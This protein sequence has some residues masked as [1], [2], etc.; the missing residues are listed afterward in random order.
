MKKILIA[1]ILLAIPYLCLAQDLTRE[2]ITA[3]VLLKGKTL[4]ITDTLVINYNDTLKQWDGTQWNILGEGSTNFQGY[5]VIIRNDSILVDTS[6][7]TTLYNITSK[8]DKADT[9]LLSGYKTRYSS[10]LDSVKQ[11]NQILLKKDKSDSTALTG[12]NTNYKSSLKVDKTTTVNSKA[13]IGNITLTSSDFAA[14]DSATNSVQGFMTATDHTRLLNAPSGSGV[15]SQGAYWNGTNSVTGNEFWAVDAVNKK[16]TISQI[17]LIQTRATGLDLTNTTPATVSVKNQDSPSFVLGGNSW[18]T[19]ASQSWPMMVRLTATSTSTSS[20]L[21]TLRFETSQDGAYSANY[22][23]FAGGIFSGQSFVASQYGSFTSA[24]NG[25][26]SF[27][28]ALSSISAAL[29]GYN[30]FAASAAIKIQDAP[31][32]DFSSRLWNGSVSRAHKWCV[33]TIG[34]ADTENNNLTFWYSYDGGTN[35]KKIFEIQGTYGISA[36][37]KFFLTEGSG[38]T[39]PNLSMISTGKST[40]IGANASN[41]YIVGD[42]SA[43]MLLTFASKANIDAG[44]SLGSTA[45]QITSGG[46]IYKVNAVTDSLIPTSRVVDKKIAAAT[47]GA[48]TTVGNWD[49]SGNAFPTTGSGAGGIVDIGDKWTISVKG[50]VSG[51]SLQVG[52]VIIAKIA[53]PGQ[54]LA[55]WNHLSAASTTVTAIART[56]GDVGAGY[57][58]YNGT[59]SK[60]G[61][62]DGGTTTPTSLNKTLNFNG[63]FKSTNLNIFGISVLNPRVTDVVGSVG[64]LFNT[65]HSLTAANNFIFDFKNNNTSVLRYSGDGWLGINSYDFAK[66]I[67]SGGSS[68]GNRIWNIAGSLT[69]NTNNTTATGLDVSSW[70]GKSLNIAHRCYTSSNNTASVL[71]INRTTTSSG[72]STGNLVEI[73]DGGGGSGSL[74]GK[75]LKVVLGS[76]STSD[77]T[78]RIYF[79]PRVISTGSALAYMFDTHTSLGA[80][81][82]IVSFLNYGTEMSSIDATGTISYTGSLKSSVTQTTVNG[83]TSG[84]A[85]F[86]PTMQGASEKKVIIY[87][88]ALNG[89]A[90]YTFPV[91]FTYTPDKLGSNVSLVTSLSTTGITVTGSTSTGFIE[92]YGF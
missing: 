37:N 68:S 79:N 12:F 13:L 52:D 60:E 90:T 17:N 67:T 91:A 29:Y 28:P 40:S 48:L 14:S 35:V 43:N 24:R 20:G 23:T 6:K 57:L 46:N 59:V 51:D 42:N 73:I 78:E 88:N 25:A 38:G 15:S 18:G 76:P 65:E 74:S 71:N 21:S 72:N 63:I 16:H 81:D 19:T 50:I 11:Y 49:A 2:K 86:S 27:N 34:A 32:I 64:Y 83:S 33:R 69:L 36:A 92:I 75:V 56:A 10:D 89:T 47:N 53:S 31:G 55:N 39:S 8:K 45:I 4:F 9:L 7:I 77:C 80:G 5:G 44:T 82:K 87:C 30:T 70:G 54:T 22:G 85:I 3:T 26:A 62:F 41:S 1:I 66:D 61:Q 58:A 84:T